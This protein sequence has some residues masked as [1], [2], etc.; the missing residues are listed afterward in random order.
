LVTMEQIQQAQIDAMLGRVEDLAP[1]PDDANLIR[2]ALAANRADVDLWDIADRLDR[3]VVNL[4]T[5]QARLIEVRAT[6]IEALREV[7]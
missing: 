7:E 1:H 2:A 4:T 5:Q 3:L 6:I